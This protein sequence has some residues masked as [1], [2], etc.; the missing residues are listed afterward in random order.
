MNSELEIPWDNY[1]QE[2]L[3][4]LELAPGGLALAAALIASLE[5]KEGQH[6]LDFCPGPEVL[7]AIIANE[8]GIK[9]TSIV[10]DPRS[11]IL[12]EDAADELGVSDLVR[13]IP[14]EKASM[15]VPSEEFDRI[16]CLGNPFIPPPSPELAD[17]VL[18]VMKPG[19]MVGFAGPSSLRN[20]TPQYMEQGLMDFHAGRLRT[21]A[22]TAL[23][24]SREGFHIAVAEY[25]QGTWDLWKK[26]LEIVPQGY[27]PDSFRKALVEDGGRWLSLSVVVLR[28]PPKPDWAV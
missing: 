25:V 20:D 16:F 9:V 17:E 19:G 23:Q 24:L 1:P 2:Y 5:P 26:W 10:R 14:G 3:R 27:V 18:R 21:P 6:W 12:L 4:Q 7:A 15:P 13:V 28:K 22:W 11:E 8:L